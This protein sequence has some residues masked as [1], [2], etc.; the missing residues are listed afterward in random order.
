[1]IMGNASPANEQT[2]AEYDAKQLAS[3]RNSYRIGLLFT[4]FLHIQMKLTQPLVYSSV[5][6]LVDLFYVTCRAA[7][8]P[9]RTSREYTRPV[10]H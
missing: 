2:A 8:P 1:M 3:Q 4:A 7:P 6:G 10:S 9:G 5:S